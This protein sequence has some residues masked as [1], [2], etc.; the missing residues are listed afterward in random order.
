MRRIAWGILPFSQHRGSC[1]G[2][3]PR[4]C[5]QLAGKHIP[6]T[7]GKRSQTVKVAFDPV[8]GSSAQ[9]CAAIPGEARRD[10]TAFWRSG[11]NT[12]WQR[13]FPPRTTPL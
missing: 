1:F 8:N 4:F 12:N 11:S 13:A 9:A 6:L 2:D 3:A 5:S 10:P 7:P